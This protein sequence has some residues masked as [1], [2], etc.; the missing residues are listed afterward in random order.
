MTILYDSRWIGS[1]GIGRSAQELQRLLPDLI[2]FSSHRAPSHPLDPMFVAAMLWHRRPDLYFSPGYNPPLS[3]P[4]PF[5]FTLHD[6]NHLCVPENSSIT[7]RAYYEHI[8]RPAC[9]KAAFVL[10]VSEYSKSQ[11]RE[12]AGIEEAK[13]INVGSG[14]GPPF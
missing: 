12:W 9:H 6:L 8:I 2:P 4:C 10:T 14:V 13:I 11:I 7:K 5:V 3:S 1:Y